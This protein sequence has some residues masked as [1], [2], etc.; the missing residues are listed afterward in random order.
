MM[1]NKGSFEDFVNAIRSKR[2]GDQI[3][4][5]FIPPYNGT[6]EE[7]RKEV[8]PQGKEQL[9]LGVPINSYIETGKDGKVYLC[10]ITI[11]VAK[12]Q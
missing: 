9:V 10:S 8:P 11:L 5:E 3:T 7:L 12:V 1:E 2:N 6:V 4:W